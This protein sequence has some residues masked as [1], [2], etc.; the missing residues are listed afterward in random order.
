MPNLT[1]WNRADRTFWIL[2]CLLIPIPLVSLFSHHLRLDVELYYRYSSYVMQGQI[3]YRDFNVE[4]PPLALGPMVVPQ[5]LNL[6]FTRGF[7]GYVLLL[8]L[9]NLLLCAL[10][11]YLLSKMATWAYGPQGS[12]RVTAAYWLLLIVSLPLLLQRFDIFPACLTL[13]GLWF[14]VVQRPTLSGMALGL[15]VAA[16][17]YP[18]IL[19]PV[20]GLYYLT[21]RQVGACVR[22][23]VGSA[24]GTCLVLLPF[25]TVGFSQLTAFLQY[26]KLR[27]LQLESIPAGL[28]LLAEKLGWTSVD[29]V[30]NYGAMHLKSALADGTVKLLA[31]LFLVAWG[32]AVVSCVKRFQASRKLPDR[33]M[34][35]ALAQAT[36][37]LLLV[38]IVTN[39]VFSPQYLIWLLPFIPFLKPRQVGLLIAID[40]LSLLV[41]PLLYDALIDR[42][43]LPI[44][45]LNARNLAIVA[46]TLWVGIEPF[47]ASGD[48][49]TPTLE[50]SQKV[51]LSA[52][53]GARFEG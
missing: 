7:R 2:V 10:S 5:L 23:V 27:G 21:R 6:G 11:G 40:W 41:Y 8:F 48:R 46:L 37:L 32:L 16:K 28:I 45:L 52:A 13:L 12:R 31:P 4:Y 26:H 44:L 19:I 38:F 30:V 43:I 22:L 25:A 18:V 9:Q 33:Q 3:P 24:I 53:S 42:Q 20:F 49:L 47:R 36:A 17:L 15:G 14:L 29:L 35:P 1:L 50:A 51:P 39:K 34:A